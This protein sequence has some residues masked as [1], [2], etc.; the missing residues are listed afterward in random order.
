[1]RSHFITSL[2][3]LAGL[4]LFSGCTPTS[5]SDL[6]QP[7]PNVQ[8]NEAQ[9]QTVTSIEIIHINNCGGKGNSEQITE[10]S[11]SVNIEGGL[12]VQGG[13]EYLQ[14][15]VSGK[16]GQYRNYSKS[17]KVI[18]PPGTNMEFEIKWT[19]LEWTGT[20][21]ASGQSGKY[22]VHA[23][24]EVEQISS[25]DK[26]SC[27]NSVPPS[28]EQPTAI[29]QPQ[30]DS[31]NCSFINELVTKADVIK[32]LYE[33]QSLAGVQA[34]LIY[35]IDVPIGWIVQYDGKDYYGPVHFDSGIVASFWSPNSCR[36]LSI[37]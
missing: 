10:R 2:I 29:V 27:N 13:V 6:T 3:T 8:I 31:M 24:I 25:Q 11:F 23:P 14:G 18:A 26:G 16:Y 20:L 15:T 1:M 4:I 22:N 35:A 37:Q 30:L 28:S 12:E 33:G 21:T 32:K 34:R 5:P 19:E 9:S 17:L 36:P 7:N